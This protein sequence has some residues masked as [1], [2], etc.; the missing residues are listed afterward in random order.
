MQM[1]M[2]FQREANESQA[3][4]AELLLAQQNQLL[5]QQLIQQF[6]Q[7]PVTKPGLLSGL[8]TPVTQLLSLGGFG[9]QQGHSGVLG[10]LL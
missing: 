4:L 7:R 9:Y 1:M 8:L 2:Q 10:G 3:R 6:P 5:Q